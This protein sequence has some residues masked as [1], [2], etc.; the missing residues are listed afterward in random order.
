ME[1]S[2]KDKAY[3][4]I[5]KEV[6]TLSDFPRVQIG[7]CAV[8]QH[9]VISTGFNTKRTEPIQKKYNKY[10]GFMKNAS[11]TPHMCHAEISCLKSL[12]NR[13]DIDFNRVHLYI[14]RKYGKESVGLSRPCEG[15]MQL[16]KQLGIKNIHYTNYG[17]YSHEVIVY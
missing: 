7:C 14:W 6:S 1:L 15:C 10:R 3:F 16:I 5:A 2:K 11:E 17:G 13:N 4:N 12:I 9:K 8:Y